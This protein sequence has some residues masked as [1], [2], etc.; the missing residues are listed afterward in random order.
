MNNDTQN[1][2]IGNM[3]Y[4]SYDVLKKSIY[5]YQKYLK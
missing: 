5:F 4:R 1:S 2:Y 3:L